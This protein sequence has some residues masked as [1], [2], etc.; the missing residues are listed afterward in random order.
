VCDWCGGPTG[1]RDKPY[2]FGQ[3]EATLDLHF[4]TAELL[5]LGTLRRSVKLTRAG[6]ASPPAAGDIEAEP[7]HG[8][9]S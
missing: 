6:V 9:N 4:N 8:G 3:L 1:D 5:A 7:V 2:V